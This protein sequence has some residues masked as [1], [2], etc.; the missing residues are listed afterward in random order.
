MITA[1][2]FK[3]GAIVVLVAALGGCTYL[4]SDEVVNSPPAQLEKTTKLALAIQQLPP[5]I[6]V[7]DVAVYQFPDR[8]GQFQTNDNFA[9]NS[10]AVTQGASAVLIDVLKEVGG[11]SWFEVVERE[12]VQALLQERELIIRTRQAYEGNSATALPALRFAGTIIEGG[13]VGYDTNVESG[14][15]GATYLGIGG[16]VEY[17]TDV[18]TVALRTVSVSSGR[19]LTSVTTT[20][21]IHSILGRAGVFTFAAVDRIFDAEVG[22][23]KNEPTQI[24]VREAIELAVLMTIIEG[25]EKGIFEFKDKAQGQQVIDLVRGRFKSTDQLAAERLEGLY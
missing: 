5:P 13:V 4:R 24:A 16:N 1:S 17:R 19:V 15:A 22:Y 2:F 8:T 18:V 25:V 6:Q 3:A 9:E 14:G 7:V 20:K 10:R 12:G 21:T 11:G 23:S